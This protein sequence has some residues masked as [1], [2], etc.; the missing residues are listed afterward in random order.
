MLPS[1]K[2]AAAV[3]RE[4]AG[5]R[6]ASCGTHSWDVLRANFRTRLRIIIASD[7]SLVSLS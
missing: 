4:P 2:E 6:A 3:D 1:W 5:S 7:E